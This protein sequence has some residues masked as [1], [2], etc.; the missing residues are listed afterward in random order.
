MKETAGE[1]S[2]EHPLNVHKLATTEPATQC[3]AP[4]L[5]AYKTVRELTAIWSVI[6]NI[7][8]RFVAEGDAK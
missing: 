7:A 6:L 2:A 1:W 4:Q 5:I 3:P 8:P